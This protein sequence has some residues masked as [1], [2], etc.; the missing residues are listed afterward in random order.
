MCDPSAMA[1]ASVATTIGSSA[2]NYL[3]QSKA[4]GQQEE[5]N[6]QMSAANAE[7]KLLNA[8]A[9][10]TAYLEE[11]HMSGIREQ[12]DSEAT[13]VSNQQSY[14]QNMQAK[15]TAQ[16]S[17]AEGGVTGNSIQSLFAGYDRANAT[18]DYIA[19]RNLQLK[20]LQSQE[21]MKAY[22]SKA[23][24]SINMA[25]QYVPTPVIQPSLGANLLGGIGTALTTYSN[26]T[27]QAEQS[28]YHRAMGRNML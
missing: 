22:Q 12:E 6:S 15:A 17:A 26:Y 10:Q 28:A 5:Y 25:Q 7:Y 2:V 1:V 13:E 24:S 21:Q 27:T 20:G 23:I 16:T 14:I 8:Q 18:N 9:T 4:A 11:M 19:S 3:G